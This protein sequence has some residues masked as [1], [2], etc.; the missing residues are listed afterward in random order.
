MIRSDVDRILYDEAS[1]R[2]H[3]I[4]LR[5]GQEIF[6]RKAVISSSGYRNTVNNLLSEDITKMYQIPRD[7]KVKQSAG[8]VMTNIGIN[9]AA[10][11]IGATKANTWHIPLTNNGDIFKPMEDFFAD[12]LG[13]NSPIPAFITFPSLKD[14]AFAKKDKTSCQML[15]L[16]DY[17]WFEKYYANANS[18]NINSME[19]TDKRNDGYDACKEAWKERC[20]KIFLQHFPKAKDYIELVD[21]STPLSIMHYLRAAQGAAVGLDVSPERFCDEESRDALDCITKIPGLAL[22]GQD[23]AICGVTLCQLS[24]VVTAFRLEGVWAAVKIVMQSVFLGDN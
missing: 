6:C 2:V 5:S 7:I 23:T 20:L 4:R 3:G 13:E 15:V 17:A 16:V 14:T 18:E 19:G 9:C 22:T 1:K 11:V 24:G 10:E 8:F 12:P 21:I